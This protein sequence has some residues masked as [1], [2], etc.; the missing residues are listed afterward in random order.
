V[1]G[2]ALILNA[3]S[4]FHISYLGMSSF[5]RFDLLLL[6]SEQGDERCLWRQVGEGIIHECAFAR[7]EMER[8]AENFCQK[9]QDQLNCAE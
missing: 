5:E 6:K 3:Y 4:R 7:D 2:T 1:H 8:V 9:F